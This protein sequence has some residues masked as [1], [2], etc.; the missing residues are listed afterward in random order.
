MK[1]LKL[2]QKKTKNYDIIDYNK[3]YVIDF[4]TVYVNKGHIFKKIGKLKKIK[5]YVK[6]L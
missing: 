1:L 3:F 4:N 6:F 2:Y 5:L